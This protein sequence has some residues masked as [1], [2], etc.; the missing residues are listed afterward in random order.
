V[1]VVEMNPDE[2]WEREFGYTQYARDFAGRQIRKGAYKDGSDYE[3]DLDH[4]LP[5]KFKKN[6][7]SDNI[8]NWQ[9]THVETNREK[10]DNNP[11]VIGNKRY[12][13]KKVNNLYEEDKVA[14]YPYERNGKKYCIIILEE[15]I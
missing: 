13:I 3:W 5:L 4:I 1:E 2:F 8:N 7:K 11:F 6:G 12:Q 15:N 14:P 9:I 10:A